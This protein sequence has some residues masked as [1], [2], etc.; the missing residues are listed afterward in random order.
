MIRARSLT[1]RG[2]TGTTSTRRSASRRCARRDW[3]RS[4]QRTRDFWREPMSRSIRLRPITLGL[5][6]AGLLMCSIAAAGAQSAQKVSLRL[7][8]VISGYHAPSVVGLKNGY[9]KDRG[10][11][12]AHEPGHDSP[13]A[14][15]RG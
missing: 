2:P 10:P 11:R 12:V 4:D 8:W 9:Y 5:A 3:R 13:K 1:S 6:S 14:A 7:D 15:P